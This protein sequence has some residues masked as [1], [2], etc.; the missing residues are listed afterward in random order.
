MELVIPAREWAFSYAW[1]SL[2]CMANGEWELSLL[3]IYESG[4]EFWELKVELDIYI[5][6]FDFGVT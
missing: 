6:I 2:L 5:F 1:N 3:L 4:Y